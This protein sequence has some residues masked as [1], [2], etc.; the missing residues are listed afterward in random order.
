MTLGQESWRAEDAG[1]GNLNFILTS[2]T[3]SSKDKV[4]DET[5]I[6][7]LN[8]QGEIVSFNIDNMESYAR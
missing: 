6:Y 4:V 7:T 8:P 3:F 1:K 2:K 5:L